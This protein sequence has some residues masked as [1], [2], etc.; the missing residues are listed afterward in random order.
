MSIFRFGEMNNKNLCKLIWIFTTM[1]VLRNLY[2]RISIFEGASSLTKFKF[3]LGVFYTSYIEPLVFIFL[4]KFIC[5]L[6]YKFLEK[7]N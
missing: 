1:L 4:F 6:I 2:I 7:K 3:H 5:E